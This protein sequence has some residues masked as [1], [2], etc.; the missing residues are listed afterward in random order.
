MFLLMENIH[1]EHESFIK[2]LVSGNLY[3]DFINMDFHFYDSMPYGMLKE[4]YYFKKN[5][6]IS[7]FREIID[8]MY[9]LHYYS[10]YFS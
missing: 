8:E 6:K 7:I 2:T 3:T 5:I 1:C 4:G 10:L 9:F